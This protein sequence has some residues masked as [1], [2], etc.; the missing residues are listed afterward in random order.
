M[1]LPKEFYAA[2]RAMPFHEATLLMVTSSWW[3]EGRAKFAAAGKTWSEGQWVAAIEQVDRMI[4]DTLFER[5]CEWFEGFL[6]SRV[7]LLVKVMGYEGLV[8]KAG[9]VRDD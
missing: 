5:K 6:E 1:K 3:S 7:R 4:D 9:E 8:Q 2:C